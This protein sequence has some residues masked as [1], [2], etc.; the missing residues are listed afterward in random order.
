MIY[1]DFFISSQ[2][3]ENHDIELMFGLAKTKKKGLLL[4]KK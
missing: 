2:C 1:F 3:Q 4:A